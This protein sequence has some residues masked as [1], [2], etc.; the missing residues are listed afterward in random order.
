MKSVKLFV[1]YHNVIL[2]LSHEFKCSF[3]NNFYLHFIVIRSL[4]TNLGIIETVIFI[5]ENSYP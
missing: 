1:L 4:D 3:N 5:D 2:K